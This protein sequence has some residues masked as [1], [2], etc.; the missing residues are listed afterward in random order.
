[1]HTRPLIHREIAS[2]QIQDSKQKDVKNQHVHPAAW[3]FVHRLPI[4]AVL[5][6]LH[7]ST[8]AAVAVQMAASAAEIM[9]A[10]SYRRLCSSK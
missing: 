7:H 4:Y 6:L 3:N 10:S 8:A 1:M 5:S 2:G 9:H